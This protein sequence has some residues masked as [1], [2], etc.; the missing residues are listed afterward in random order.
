VG[1]C[2]IS[3][4]LYYDLEIG[5]LINYFAF[6]T[7]SETTPSP[8][9]ASKKTGGS[10][11]NVCDRFGTEFKHES[12]FIWTY[13]EQ[14]SF[15]FSILFKIFEN[16]FFFLMIIREIYD[17]L[18]HLSSVHCCQLGWSQGCDVGRTWSFVIRIN[19]RVGCPN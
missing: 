6:H 12:P 14:N 16:D 9:K 19:P 3:R 7:M 15:Y 11:L 13:R 10:T 18:S 2:H 8:K 17:S 4:G 1:W 5:Q